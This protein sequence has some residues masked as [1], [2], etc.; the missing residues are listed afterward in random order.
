MLHGLFVKKQR[1]TGLFPAEIYARFQRINGDTELA[2]AA[3]LKPET[4]V[5]YH[6]TQ[7]PGEEW[8]LDCRMLLKYMAL[9]TIVEP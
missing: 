2:P 1:S 3:H 4:A 8:M 7:Q 6:S 9:Y 5:V